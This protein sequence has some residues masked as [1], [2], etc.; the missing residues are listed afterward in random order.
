MPGV[1]VNRPKLLSANRL[2]SAVLS[3]TGIALYPLLQALRPM[4]VPLCF[5]TA[6]GLLAM[7]IWNLWAFLRDIMARAKQMHQVPCAHCR[8]FTG[9]YHLKC[10]VHP[11]KALSEEAIGCQDYEIARPE[12]MVRSP[13]ASW[14]SSSFH[15]PRD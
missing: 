7:V 5:I 2:K 15:N 3:T 12:W 13:S 10:T 8:Y 14:P 4:L 9:D 6:W 1:W 11:D